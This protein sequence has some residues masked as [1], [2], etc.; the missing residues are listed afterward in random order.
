M[1]KKAYLVGISPMV[2]V[3]VDENATEEQVLDAAINKMLEDPCEYIHATHCF[4]VKEDTECPYIPETDSDDVDGIL[5]VNSDDININDTSFHHV[6][7]NTSVEKLAKVLGKPMNG[8]GGCKVNYE[9]KLKV[10]HNGE[11]FVATI[12]DWKEGRISRNQNIEFHIGGF[13]A[14]EE[15][16]AKDYLEKLLAK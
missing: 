3:V 6:T 12:Y 5:A 8:D 13:S 9:W 11:E 4:E 1:N 14:S 16:I 2:R 10:R 7:I 15:R